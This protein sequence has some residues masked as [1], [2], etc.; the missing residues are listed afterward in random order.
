M[1]ESQILRQKVA[2]ALRTYL[3]PPATQEVPPNEL[4]D[5]L[6]G[7]VWYHLPDL[8]RWPRA[9]S[10]DGLV[11]WE[12]VRR[13]QRVWRLTGTLYI[14][15]AGVEPFCAFVEVEAEFKSLRSYRLHVGYLG[16]RPRREFGPGCD[17][18]KKWAHNVRFPSTAAA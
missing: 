5:A 8:S 9:H 18:P 3:E 13:K 2:N 7:L 17:P 11:I 14:L 10:P 16:E 1:E 4:G 6:E 15:P 12:V